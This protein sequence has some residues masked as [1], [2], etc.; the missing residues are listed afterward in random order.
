MQLSGLPPPHSHPIRRSACQLKGLWP[1]ALW[2]RLWRSDARWCGFGGVCNCELF[3]G[4]ASGVCVAV[5]C[6]V[7]S[8]PTTER[9]RA[10]G[11]QRT[12][13]YAKRRT[14][15]LGQSK[16]LRTAPQKT[17]TR[18]TQRGRRRTE[19][20]QGTQ[21]TTARRL[22]RCFGGPSITSRTG[23]TGSG[24]HVTVCQSSAHPRT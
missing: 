14:R 10:N 24:C 7:H 19:T 21:D 16:R 23:R 9:N 2:L 22:H 6:G 12:N 20:Q 11:T 4:C 3:T 1:Q 18:A 15:L 17:A 5:S 13:R 8:T